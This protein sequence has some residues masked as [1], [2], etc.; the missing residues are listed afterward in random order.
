MSRPSLLCID[1]AKLRVRRYVEGK[2]C[3]EAVIELP[4]H[5]DTMT[6]LEMYRR[7]GNRYVAYESILPPLPPELIA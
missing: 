3:G 4:Q 7:Y 5:A 1:T 6:N 2:V